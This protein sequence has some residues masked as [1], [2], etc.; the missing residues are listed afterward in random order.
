MVGQLFGALGQ[1]SVLYLVTTM[2]SKTTKTPTMNPTAHAVLTALQKLARE[3]FFGEPLY[4]ELTLT[5]DPDGASSYREGDE[6]AEAWGHMLD[7]IEWIGEEADGG[8]VGMWKTVDGWPVIYLSNDGELA[9]TGLTL[10]DH[11]AHVAHERSGRSEQDCVELLAF[12]DAA[13]LAPPRSAVGRKQSLKGLP[14]PA[15]RFDR[16]LSA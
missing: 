1:R 2:T 15:A 16:L 4:G 5:K 14:T 9:L 10:V 3:P 12:C 7:E 8:L 13:K 6:D 11:F